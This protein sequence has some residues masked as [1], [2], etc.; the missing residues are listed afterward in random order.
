MLKSE[1]RCLRRALWSR[2]K[3]KAEVI[4]SVG[5]AGGDILEILTNAEVIAVNQDEA[6]LPMAV[7]TSCMRK[8][9]ATHSQSDA[10]CRGP[11]L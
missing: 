7:C 4:S 8:W 6:A 3:S 1:Y 11:R 10:S 5:N 9:P 2:I